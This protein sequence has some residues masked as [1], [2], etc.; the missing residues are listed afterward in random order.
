MGHRGFLVEY[1]AAVY[2]HILPGSIKIF[3]RSADPFISTLWKFDRRRSRNA[4]PMARFLAYDFASMCTSNVRTRDLL[5][6]RNKAIEQA[7]V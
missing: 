5:T 3:Y 7:N 1:W 4:Q 6:H 2:L